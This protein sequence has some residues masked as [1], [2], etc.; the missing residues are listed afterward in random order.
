MWNYSEVVR[1]HY[2][3]PRNVGE[4]E[5]P[6]GVGEVGNIKCGDALR[7][8]FKLD[9][10]KRVKEMKFKT[11]GCGSAIASSS[12]LTELCIGKTLEE[13]EKITN[14]DIADALGGL[15]P[16][17]MHCS[18]MGQEGIEAAIRYYRTGGKSTQTP[19]KDGTIVCT[20]FSIT[21]I[22]IEK[23]ITD[24]HLKTV[25]E[26]TYYTKAGGGCGG[27]IDQIQG[28]LDKVNGTSAAKPAA[29]VRMTNLQKID[30][31]KKV[32]AEEISPILKNDGGD[33]EL[34]D[35][36]GNIVYVKMTG[37]CSGCQF[38]KVTQN[39]VVQDILRKHVLQELV[40]KEA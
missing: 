31:I 36:D 33:V 10:E 18:V 24:N 15:P 20:C 38:S 40:V 8:T 29:P 30:K 16:A 26:V 34:V 3:N 13:V 23:A 37:H 35:V 14:K 5:N 39:T 32:M 11:F 9:E 12:V 2:I 25:E 28:I 22:E 7:L 1:D 4:V 27:C 21:D 17:K 6:D 19:E